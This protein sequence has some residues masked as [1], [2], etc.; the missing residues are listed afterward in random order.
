MCAVG[1]SAGNRCRV[2]SEPGNMAVGLPECGVMP[3]CPC[4][5]HG[6]RIQKIATSQTPL[7]GFRLQSIKIVVELFGTKRSK[8]QCDRTAM[9]L[10]MKT[11]R[12]ENE[13]SFFGNNS[14]IKDASVTNRPFFLCA[15][16]LLCF[17][18]YVG[19]LVAHEGENHSA[20]SIVAD[21]VDVT[22]E[23]QVREFLQHARDHYDQIEGFRQ[24]S[25]FR[26]LLSVNG[27][28]WWKDT[29]YLLRLSETEVLNHHP[30]YPTAQSGT[31]SKFKDDD[32]RL[33]LRE[34]IEAA[35]AGPGGAGCVQYILDGAQ[36]WSCAI[37]FESRLTKSILVA[38]LHH[39]LQDVS[40][41][42]LKC[43]YYDVTSKTSAVDV[44]NEDTL[45]KFVDEFAEFYIDL[46]DK[47]GIQ[48]V[49][50]S[51]NC[52]RV[53]PWR[54][55]STY[56]FMMFQDD[57][58][59]V[60]NGNN[61]GLEN[62]SLD[63]TDDAGNDVGDLIVKA[64][65][66]LPEDEGAFVEY[67]WDDPTEDG[68]DVRDEE[69]KLIPGRAPGTSPKVSY[70]VRIPAATGDTL[71]VGS[72]I[73]PEDDGGG[74]AVAGA[75]DRPLSA[76]FNLF[77]IASV[78]LSATLW[79]NRS[80]EKTVMK[81]RGKG[82]VFVCALAL[83]VFFSGV[84]TAGAHESDHSDSVTASDVTVGDM[85]KMR[86]F[87]LHAKAHWED[88]TDPNKNISFE[89]SLTVDGG[90]WK[91]GEI[92]LMVINEE[93]V[94]FTQPHHPEAQNGALLSG[95]SFTDRR[96]Q[97]TVRP[98]VR[99]L[100]E[101]AGMEEGGCVENDEGRY[102]CAVK[103]THPVWNAELILVGGFHHD[104]DD[105]VFDPMACPYFISEI[106]DEPPYFKQGIGADGVSDRNTLRLFVKEFIRHFNEQ[107][108]I[109]GESFADLAGVRNCWRTLPWKYGAVYLFIM[110][111][112][113]KLVFFNG[114]T[115]ALENGSLDVTDDAGND[116][117]DLI[118]KAVKNL[119]EGEGTF[120][121]YLWDDPTE[122]GDNVRDEQGN[123]I[124]GRAPGT[125]PKVSYVERV[126]FLDQNFIIGSGFHPEDSGDNG[127]AVAGAGDTTQNAAF[128]LLLIVSALFSVVLRRNR[129]RGER[130]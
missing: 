85:E 12:L 127:C 111:E 93:A 47:I 129:R 128:N 81:G 118:V 112:E 21:Q 101:A 33:V 64:V 67:L 2:S 78:L 15:L 87:V 46:R 106:I 107:V 104:L 65:E 71:I 25:V 28:D 130:T 76:V 120:V 89:K 54:S 95:I 11:M 124:P 117:G 19:P 7:P 24:W 5:R 99:D 40:F 98:D 1:Y 69:G 42:T 34:L 62:K 8:S 44:V 59:V 17:F 92:Y 61:P 94:I 45:K 126:E 31:L 86:D 115:P 53:S 23:A 55:G 10:R 32:D 38:G 83:L 66:S 72:G 9:D 121:E 50:N 49:I 68:D 56:I 119:P 108:D 97:R 100:I 109:A 51:L 14:V 29:T 16:V 30:Y 123:L 110:T 6:N 70:V 75:G 63:V 22:D 113:H 57:Q 73:Y 43:P 3:R 125:S 116:V 13:E 90:D 91:N 114:N 82:T 79:K 52:F 58:N 4:V 105:I 74:C 20:D 35:D 84:S 88:I 37:R 41:A 26:G 18:S 102:S 60:F 80:R 39:N 103:F 77:L 27:G 36:R 96:R 122:D 48:E